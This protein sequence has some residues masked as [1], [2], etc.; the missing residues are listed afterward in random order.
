MLLFAVDSPKLECSTV[1]EAS[2]GDR[3]F[4]LD[5]EINAK[6]PVTDVFWILDN[7]GTVLKEGEQ[8]AEYM[9]VITVSYHLLFAK[10]K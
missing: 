9:T 4:S 7:N 6:P 1:S 8:N 3:D 5:C 10:T 2:L